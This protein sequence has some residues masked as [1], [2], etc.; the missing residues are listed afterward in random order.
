MQ[1][2]KPNIGKIKIGSEF[3]SCMSGI[4]QVGE[5][6]KAY[7]N[8]RIYKVYNIQ[9]RRRTK[10]DKLFDRTFDN[11]GNY[12]KYAYMEDISQIVP[13]KPRDKFYV[14][15]FELGGD[16]PHGVYTTKRQAVLADIERQQKYCEK[17]A[18]MESQNAEYQAEERVL[19]LLKGLLTKLKK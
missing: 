15:K 9:K 11:P 2:I 10:L 5:K 18:P 14:K 13:G 19:K 3:Y 4:E 16:L 12:P 6:W 17:Y 7:A 8:I 1:K